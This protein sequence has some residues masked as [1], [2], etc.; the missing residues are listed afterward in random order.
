MHTCQVGNV[1]KR[2][3]SLSAS[4]QRG[5]FCAKPFRNITCVNQHSNCENDKIFPPY[6]GLK[7]DIWCIAI[8][9]CTLWIL[10]WLALSLQN[11]IHFTLFKEKMKGRKWGS[12]RGRFPLLGGRWMFRREMGSKRCNDVWV[13]AGT[14]VYMKKNLQP[15]PC[16]K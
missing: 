11:S 7:L 4:C 2:E 5:R 16:W 3:I 10:C 15:S 13:S 1:Q 9:Y 6:D 12:K 8:Y 14:V